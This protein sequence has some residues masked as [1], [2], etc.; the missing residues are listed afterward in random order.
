LIV[1]RTLAAVAKPNT[2]EGIAANLVR[3]FEKTDKAVFLL[4]SLNSDE[5]ASTRMK[6]GERQEDMRGRGLRITINLVRFREH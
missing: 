3:V 1:I 4:D 5:I 2:R 6:M